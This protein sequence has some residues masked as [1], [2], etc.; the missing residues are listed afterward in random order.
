MGNAKNKAIKDRKKNLPKHVSLVLTIFLGVFGVH[1]FIIHRT[2]MG[3]LHIVLSVI[4]V[5]AVFA[6]RDGLLVITIFY[7]NFVW[8]ICEA[9]LYNQ[10]NKSLNRK[11]MSH[12]RKN[13]C[14]AAFVFWII[15][16]PILM[17]IMNLLAL[18]SKSASDAGVPGALALFYMIPCLPILC[19][20]IV[21][22]AKAISLT[23]MLNRK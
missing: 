21:F 4:T 19:C 2:K 23:R 20:A 8:G 1:D 13:S 22:T 9:V 17:N 6:V 10:G 5:G 14:I 12:E 7:A 15:C 3:F 18:D 11:G 16:T